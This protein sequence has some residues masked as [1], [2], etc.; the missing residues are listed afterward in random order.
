M[1][2]F[3]FPTGAAANLETALRQTRADF[4]FSTETAANLETVL[5]HIFNNF[6]V[7]G[8]DSLAVSAGNA[9]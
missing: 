7:L 6:D 8:T 4:S 2:R 3:S 5:R 1:K 9:V